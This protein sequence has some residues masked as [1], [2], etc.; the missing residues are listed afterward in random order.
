[1][2]ILLILLILNLLCIFICSYKLVFPLDIAG[3]QDLSPS[4][5]ILIQVTSVQLA[6]F[7]YFQQTN[8]SAFFLKHSKL[9]LSAQWF[10]C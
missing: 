1:M 8:V 2:L 5:V 3:L 7:D 6:S 10:R 4:S 9:Y